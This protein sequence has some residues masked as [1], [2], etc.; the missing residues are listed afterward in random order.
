MLYSISIWVLCSLGQQLFKALKPALLQPSST[1]AYIPSDFLVL[2]LSP[3]IT[4]YIHIIF[5][6]DLHLLH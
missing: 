2:P 4:I 6:Q 5:T 3:L 1:L